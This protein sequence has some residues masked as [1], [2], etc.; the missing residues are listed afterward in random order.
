MT[1]RKSERRAVGLEAWELLINRWATVS[2]SP[3]KRLL[4]RVIAQAIADSEYRAQ[5]DGTAISHSW[6]TTAVHA[7]CR[8]IG[9]DA[10]ALRGEV[11]RAAAFFGLKEAA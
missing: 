1:K 3:E 2:E 7:Y 8:L 5:K 9:V 11:D 6:L 10:L 4:V